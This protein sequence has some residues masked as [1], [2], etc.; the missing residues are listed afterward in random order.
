[1]KSLFKG[2]VSI[3]DRFAFAGVTFGVSLMLSSIAGLAQAAGEFVEGDP[4]AGEEKAATC[5]ACHGPAGNS[6]AP[7]F[8]KL[9]G[10]VA[11]YTDLQLHLIKS[12]ERPVPQMAGIAD[13]LSDQDMA[14]LAAYYQ[15]TQPT[16]AVASPDTIELGEQLYRA[17]NSAKGV[18]ACAGCHDPLGRGNIPAGFPR[19]AGQ[20]TDYITTQLLAYRNGE[21]TAGPYAAMMQ[22]VAANLSDKEIA[23]LSNYI[24][25]LTAAK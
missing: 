12:N 16:P 18:P 24:Q 19:L 3:P 9:S 13:N 10:Q 2:F 6:A 5:V 22:G 20:H 1:M 11:K 17:G 25:G 14:D 15:S 21:R 8:P 23:A 7:M 4:A